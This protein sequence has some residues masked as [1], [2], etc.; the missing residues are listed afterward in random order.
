M[1]RQPNAIVLNNTTTTVAGLTIAGI[2][3]P[4][5]TPDKNTSPAGSGLTQQVADQ[6][7]GAGDQLAATVRS[8]PRP[9]NIA[10]V[11]DPASAGPLAGTCP[12]VLAGHTHARQVS[13]LPRGARRSSRTTL[14]VEGS[15]GGAGLRGLEGEKPTPL[16]MTCSTSTSRSCSRRTT[17]SPSAAPG[18]PR[19]T[20]NGTW[21]RTRPPV[22]PPRPPPRRPAVSPPHPTPTPTG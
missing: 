2:G 15:T 3:D 16:S 20:W 13:E 9:V 22:S 1:A 5:F 14:M 4:R 8:S 18:R 6:V 11:H 21:W 7:I 12:L 17:T 10:L 19:S